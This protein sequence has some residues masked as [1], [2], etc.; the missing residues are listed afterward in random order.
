MSDL[1]AVNF[2]YLFKYII[3]GD[4]AVGKSNLLLKY[5]QDQFKPEYQLTIGVEFG[6]KNLEIRKKIY[7]IQIWDTAG[8]ENFRSITRA[9]YKNSICAIVVY[10]ITSRDTFNNV[11]IWIEDC[12]NQCPKSIFMVL[13][14]NKLDLDAKR[15][16]SSD[17]G[18][19]LAEKNG[20]LFF[21]TS[22]KDGTNV[23]NIF[24]EAAD[25]IANNIDQNYYDLDEENCGI[26]KEEYWRANSITY[27]MSCDYYRKGKKKKKCCKY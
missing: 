18:R 5:T 19:E 10:D 8:Q 23:E 27:Q 17:E 13:V 21:E 1:E 6:T 12:K 25:N 26:I 14:G 4:A 2:D 7:R 24:V 16:I 9:Y 11:S 3:I 20:M 22:A 15:E